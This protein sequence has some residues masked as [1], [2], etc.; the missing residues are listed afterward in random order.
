MRSPQKPDA[1]FG[2]AVAAI[3]GDANPAGGAMGQGDA[4]LPVAFELGALFL[5][6]EGCTPC[7]VASSALNASASAN[8]ISSID[9]KSRGHTGDQVEVGGLRA[10][11]LE[12]QSVE[13]VTI[14][15]PWS[16]RHQPRNRPRSPADL[17]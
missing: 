5:V 15:V 13:V 6:Q 12:Q 16:L 7:R 4:Q 1:E 8:T 9:A 17:I 2:V 3:E 11:G 14:H 10:F